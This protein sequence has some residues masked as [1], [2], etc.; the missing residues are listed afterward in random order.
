[1][2]ELLAAEKKLLC[3]QT[4]LL[5]DSYR[6]WTAKDLLAGIQGTD[7]TLALFNAP[8]ALV[9]HNIEEIPVF[10]YGNQTALNLFEIAWGDFIHLQSRYSAEPVNR[11]Q[12]QALLNHVTK[13]GFYDNYS[14]VRISASGKRFKIERAIIWNVIDKKGVYRGQAAKFAE[15]Q[16]LD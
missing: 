14:G 10:N 6:Y 12:R 5:I 8:F 9:S 15:W 7:Q 4:E 1:M 11:E 16:E 2:Q 13:H 3:E